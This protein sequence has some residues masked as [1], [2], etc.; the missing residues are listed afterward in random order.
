MENNS[1][2]Y[3]TLLNGINTG[4]ADHID[5]AEW[6]VR[7]IEPKVIVDLGVDYGY[8]TFSFAFPKIGEVYG[9]DSF[10][11]D[12]YSGIRDTYD[13]VVNKKKE[14]GLDNITFVKGLVDDVVEKW[15]KPIDILHIDAFH[16]YEAVKNDFT[17]WSKF[18]DKGVILLHDTLVEDAPFG[19]KKFFGEITLPKTN[20]EFCNGLGVVSKNQKIIDEI[21]EN[22]N[23]K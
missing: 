3:R 23:L 13:F 8:S 10:E 22:F 14:L 16:T 9:I 1:V 12:P 17:K 18:V 19:V 5:F 2:E 6:L 4:W 21:K 7:K 20:F 11:G 15:E